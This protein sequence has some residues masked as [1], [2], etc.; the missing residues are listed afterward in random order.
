M[1]PGRLTS[2][3]SASSERELGQARASW[4]SRSVP[5]IAIPQHRAPESMRE[6]E[7]VTWKGVCVERS[8]PLFQYNFISLYIYGVAVFTASS[9]DPGHLWAAPAPLAQ[10]SGVTGG[11]VLLVSGCICWA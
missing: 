6:L 4:P 3:T 9:S 1:F 2:G 8:P 7:A 10:G 11:P 5:I